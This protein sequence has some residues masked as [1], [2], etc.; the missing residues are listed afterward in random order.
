MRS[1]LL[2]IANGS[3]FWQMKTRFGRMTRCNPIHEIDDIHPMAR[4]IMP[5]IPGISRGL[6][7]ITLCQAAGGNQ[8]LAAFLFCRQL[9][10]HIMRLFFGNCY[11]TAGIYNQDLRGLVGV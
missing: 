11:K 7:A 8:D 10:E 6:S 2:V 3:R 9:R 5:S 1:T 4:P